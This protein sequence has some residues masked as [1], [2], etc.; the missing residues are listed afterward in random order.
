MYN[1]GKVTV[2]IAVKN[3]EE[4][5][6]DTLKCLVEQTV[7]PERV[8]IVNDRSEDR[9]HYKV[10]SF[11][12]K[13]KD[14]GINFYID[15]LGETRWIY[16]ARNRGA[17]TVDTEYMFFLDGDDIVHNKYIETMVD[18]LEKNKT[19]NN[20]LVGFA[21]CQHHHFGESNKIYDVPDYDIGTLLQ[22]NFIA[23]SSMMRTEVFKKSGGYSEYLNETRNH[24]TEWHFWINLFTKNVIGIR[25]PEAYFYYRIS[26]KNQMSYSHERYRPDMFFQIL[27]KLD[28]TIRVDDSDRKKILLVCQ[29]KDYIDRSKFGFEGYTWIKPLNDWGEVYCFFYDVDMSY[30]GISRMN[31]NLMTMVEKVKPDYV[32]HPAYKEHIN[33]LTW[34]KI[35]E[36]SETI[37]WFS[38]D[39]RRF[40]SYSL[41]YSAGFKI[42]ATTYRSAYEGYKKIYKSKR[43]IL[44]QWAANEHYYVGEGVNFD[45]RPTD[46]CF[47]GQVYGDRKENIIKII[48]ED[49]NKSKIVVGGKGWKK[50]GISGN[51]DATIY[52][53]IDF[54]NMVKELRNSKIVLNFSKGIDGKKQI[55]M[56]PFE[57]CCC[58]AL[59]LTEYS[60]GLEQYFKFSKSIIINNDDE[61]VVFNS[62]EELLEKLKFLL[63]NEE[64]RKK[65]A[66]NGF[67]NVYDNHL[68]S[69]RFKHFF[70]YSRGFKNE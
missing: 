1:D 34:K 33:V 53:F 20:Y 14:C 6:T 23:Y 36:V 69:N 10:V 44:T 19:A 22:R 61:I 24:M 5:I 45:K 64:V 18:V 7:K 43:I 25:V 38:D 49:E 63:A 52:D 67:T 16:S 60:D 30:S 51:S 42:I 3:A 26:K 48:T 9:T 39:D 4:T 65:I 46:I 17:E 55:K 29:G 50:A 28:D 21:Y 15:M 57:I 40:E 11:I 47:F 8:V 13:N 56:R 68:W 58:G 59:C 32:F 2:I 27:S 66:M 37:V 54:P 31:E 12:G 41:Y 70:P 62:Q 35:S